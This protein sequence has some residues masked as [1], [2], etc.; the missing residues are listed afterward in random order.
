MLGFG[1]L[2][3]ACSYDSADNLLVPPACDP[4]AG[5]YAAVVAPLIQQRCLT[6]HSNTARG[7]DISLETHTQVQVVALNGRLLGAVSHAPGYK[8][9]PQGAPKISDCEIEQIRRW[10]AAGSPNN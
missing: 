1:L 2:L 5:S 8:A 4:A 7:G 3:T 6:C 10:V 9:M